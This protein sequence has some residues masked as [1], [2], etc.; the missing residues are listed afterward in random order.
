MLWRDLQAEWDRDPAFQ[1][2]WGRFCALMALR[3]LLCLHLRQRRRAAQVLLGPVRM[4]CR[5]N[6]YKPLSGLVIPT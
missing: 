4:Q 2:E 5:A 1:A 6:G 3:D